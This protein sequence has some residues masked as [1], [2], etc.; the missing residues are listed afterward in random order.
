MGL[1]KV[2]GGPFERPKVPRSSKKPLRAPRSSQ[3]L[4]GSCQSLPEAPKSYKKLPEAPRGS[5]KL[6]GG[7]QK[8]PKVLRSSRKLPEACRKLVEAPRGFQ[9]AA[10]NSQELPKT[11]RSLRQ[12]LLSF[13]LPW[14][15]PG[16]RCCALP[17]GF[18]LR[19]PG[20]GG[21]GDWRNLVSGKSGIEDMKI[22]ENM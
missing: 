8:L 20:I 22:E 12:T 11:P 2:P 9:E 15:P 10:R 6:P 19:C 21:V 3:K 1:L 14:T 16:H 7:S 17:G 5:Q 13:S 4:P 18:A